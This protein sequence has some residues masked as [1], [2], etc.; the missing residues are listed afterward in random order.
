MKINLRSNIVLTRDPPWVKRSRKRSIVFLNVCDVEQYCWNHMFWIFMSSNFFHKYVF[1]VLQYRTP[2]MVWVLSISF[3]KSTTG[4]L[5]RPKIRTKQLLSVNALFLQKSL[6]D[7]LLPKFYN[8]VWWKYQ[9]W[10]YW[11]F[12]L[13]IIPLKCNVIHDVSFQF[14]AVVSKWIF[15]LHSIVFL[16]L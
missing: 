6:V 9:F 8:F 2:L 7:S 16:I 11:H 14:Y 5:Y 15:V 3:S 12:F 13:S 10:K 4:S 1:I